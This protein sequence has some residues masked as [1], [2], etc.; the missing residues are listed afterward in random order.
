[1]GIATSVTDFMMGTGS[2]EARRQGHAEA[3]R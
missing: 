1:M 2:L 3:M